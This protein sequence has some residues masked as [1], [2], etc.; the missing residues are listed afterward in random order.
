MLRPSQSRF[1]RKQNLLNGVLERLEKGLSDE[2][3]EYT[4]P[5]PIFT[6]R[7][8]LK[9]KGRAFLQSLVLPGWGQYYAESRTMMKVFVA[10][11]AALWASFLGFSVWSNWLEDDYR[12]FAVT[13][14][15]IRLDN[16]SDKYFVDIGNF[17]D[18]LEHNQAQLRDRDVRGLYPETPE[19]FWRWDSG[20][21]RLKFEDMRVR[22]DRAANRAELSLAVVFLNHLVSAIHSTFSVH[23]FNKR[24]KQNEIGFRIHLDVEPSYLELTLIRAF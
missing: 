6:A 21:N 20:E 5:S 17:D 15:G 18:I 4:V 8:G 3:L 9:S 2:K 14:A 13:H 22:S 11:E 19:F 1:A 12:T 23:K 10:S 16:K 7:N 24:L